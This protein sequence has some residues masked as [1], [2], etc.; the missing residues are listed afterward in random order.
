MFVRYVSAVTSGTTMTLGLFYVMQ[1]LIEMEPGIVIEDRIRQDLIWLIDPPVE[2][3]PFADPLPI[4]KSF[5]DPPETPDTHAKVDSDNRLA[6]VKHSVATPSG[7]EIRVNPNV[8]SDGPLV[9][10]VRVQPTYP[11][12]AQAEGLEGYVVVQFDVLA[13][14]TVDN[15][16]V[17]ESSDTAFHRAAVKAAEKF[18]FKPRVVDGIPQVTTGL[19]NLFRFQMNNDQ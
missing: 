4:D 12:R 15:V 10:V 17:V 5:I 2:D 3:P 7:H 16:S 8:F 6:V 13:D 11:A 18:R 14:G 1:L 9:A 19:R